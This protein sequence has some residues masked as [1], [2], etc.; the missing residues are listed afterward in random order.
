L[1]NAEKP[2]D[3]LHI[4]YFDKYPSLFY[5]YYFSNIV[6]P[7]AKPNAAHKA[8]AALEREGRVK[9]V[10]TQ[11]IDGL[12]QQAG[13][14]VVLEL[15]GSVNRNRCLGCGKIYPLKDILPASD[16]YIPYCHCKAMIKPDV[17]LYGEQLNK[18]V[19][20]EAIQYIQNADMM[21][22]GGTSLSVYPAASLLHY[23][24]GNTLVLINRDRLPLDNQANIILREAIGTVLGK[25]FEL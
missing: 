14:E 21:I 9:A 3:I 22:V 12:H 15:H 23:F 24:N 17:V 5:K 2:E 1:Y 16:E 6:H 13:S 8:L 10:V 25:L 11:N 20:N 7:A 4:Q 18:R 19:I